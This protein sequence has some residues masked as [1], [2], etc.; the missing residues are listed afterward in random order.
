MQQDEVVT[1]KDALVSV[2]IQIK[3]KKLQA[4]PEGDV[5]ISSPGAAIFGQYAS[6]WERGEWLTSS[7][8]SSNQCVLMEA[9]I[10]FVT[11]FI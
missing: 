3:E 10:N 4:R 11:N 7:D 2:R 8:A 5:A 1:A 9:L 6:I